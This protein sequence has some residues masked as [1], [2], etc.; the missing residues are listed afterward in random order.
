M[1]PEMKTALAWMR[2]HGGDAAVA[3]TRAGGRVYLAQGESGPFMP[4]TA[5]NLIEAGIAEYVRDPKGQITRFRLI[6]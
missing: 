6:H 1:T 5:N 4:T 2:E 3:K